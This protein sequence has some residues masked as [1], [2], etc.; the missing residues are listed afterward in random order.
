M[1]RKHILN[2]FKKKKSHNWDTLYWSIDIH[3][4]CILSNYSVTDVPKEFFPL[5][6]EA[7][8]KISAR[9]DCRLIMWTCSYPEQIKEY[10]EF[11]SSHGIKFEF[12]NENQSAQ[13]TVYGFFEKKFYTNFILDDKAGFDAHTD[14]KIIIDALDEVE[15][16][17]ILDSIISGNYVLKSY[18]TY[19]V[20]M[21]F[22]KTIYEYEL[23]KKFDDS[24]NAF[25]K[26]MPVVIQK[27]FQDAYTKLGIT[28][29]NKTAVKIQVDNY[30]HPI[31]VVSYDGILVIVK[32]VESL[33]TRKGSSEIL[34]S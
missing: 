17:D 1:T 14:W 15:N 12:V 8:L 22:T 21:V 20:G 29:D 33:N 18:Y 23:A 9:K 3:D 10:E 30:Q 19:P 34:I 4:T 32:G 6:K 26:G 7:L 11:F 31:H 28:S 2:T 5:A 25:Y 16:G 24:D 13:N 27:I